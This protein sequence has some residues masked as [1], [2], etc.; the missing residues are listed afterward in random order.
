MIEV[1]V[2]SLKEAKKAVKKYSFRVEEGNLY[3]KKDEKKADKFEKKNGFRYEECWN[4]DSSIALF[5]LPR[6]CFLRDNLN[7]YPGTLLSECSDEDEA[8]KYW[9]KILN[10]M[11]Y[12]FYI[13]VSK[14]DYF[15]TDEEK[16]I[17]QRA[18]SWFCK[19][20]ESL[21]W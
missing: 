17:W 8:V 11:I 5:I 13:Y 9:N 14:D 19:Y 2:I 15:W 7:C 6:L 18:K 10:E 20:F 16:M 21:W 3:S 4:L 1:P 12:G